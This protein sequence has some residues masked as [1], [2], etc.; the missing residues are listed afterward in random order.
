MRLIESGVAKLGRKLGGHSTDLLYGMA[1]MI[2]RGAGALPGFGSE[3]RALG[4]S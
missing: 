2:G 4:E 1:C 3:G